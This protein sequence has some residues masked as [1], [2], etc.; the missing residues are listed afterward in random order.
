MTIPSRKATHMIR[1]YGV[2]IPKVQNWYPVEKGEVGWE[3]GF[4][5]ESGVFEFVSYKTK[6]QA[7]CD[8]RKLVEAIEE[9]YVNR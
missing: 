8:L 6:S 3:F 7:E 4:K 5:Y 2:V 1:G 9:Y